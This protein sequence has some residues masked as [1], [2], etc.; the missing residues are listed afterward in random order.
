[1][2][3]ASFRQMYYVT[4]LAGL[5]AAVPGSPK[6]WTQAHFKRNILNAGT[7][8]IRARFIFLCTYFFCCLHAG[9]AALCQN[10]AHASQQR[11]HCGPCGHAHRWLQAFVCVRVCVHVCIL[12]CVSMC[13]V[14]LR[15]N[16]LLYNGR[17]GV[18]RGS[19]ERPLRVN[20]WGRHCQVHEG[21]G[22]PIWYQQQHR[23]T[24]RLT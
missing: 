24:G 18:N 13:V 21:P 17:G 16:F 1:M 8:W 4:A 7:F 19:L 2:V 22:V 23:C 11:A 6:V 20:C 10:S 5:G 3:L 14:Y 9:A 12:V 15:L